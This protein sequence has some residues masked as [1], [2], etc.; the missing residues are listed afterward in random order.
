MIVLLLVVALLVWA[1][2]AP[3]PG[4]RRTDMMSLTGPSITLLGASTKALVRFRQDVGRY[5]GTD[6][7]LAALYAAPAGTVDWQGPYLPGSIEEFAD[8]WGRPYLYRCPA[9]FSEV[10]YDLWSRGPDGRDD[11]GAEGSDDVVN[12][13]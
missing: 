12:W 8:P 3:G 10:G 4:T 1:L 13:R 2:G 5:P 7:G 11:E 6:E 9:K